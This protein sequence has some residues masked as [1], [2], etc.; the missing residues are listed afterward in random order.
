MADVIKHKDIVDKNGRKGRSI[1]FVCLSCGTFWEKV[2]RRDLFKEKCKCKSD[3]LIAFEIDGKIQVI[4]YFPSVKVWMKS[5]T[6]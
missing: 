6:S 1:F 2:I 4:Q 5:L 3:R